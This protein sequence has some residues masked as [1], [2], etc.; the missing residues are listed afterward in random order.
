[1][2]ILA[3]PSH[4]FSHFGVIRPAT[5][6]YSDWKDQSQDSNTWSSSDDPEYQDQEDWQALLAKKDD[7]SYW[8]DFTVE[9]ETEGP[10]KDAEAASAALPTEDEAADA[11]LDTL[12]A[13]S[14]EEVEFNLKEADRADKVRQMEE[15]G[16]DAKTISNTLD[17]AMDTEREKEDVEG[18][19]LFREESYYD[20]DIDLRTVESHT[21]VEKDPETGEP[22]RS[23]MVYVDEHTW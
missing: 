14:A 10:T 9:D 3:T 5:R 21:R 15:W 18:M 6:L 20:D 1:M 2:S 7:G 12:A 19:R 11:W 13:L 23:Q 8:S 17:V 16:F 4:S 22:I